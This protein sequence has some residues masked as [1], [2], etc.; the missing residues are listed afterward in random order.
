MCLYSHYFPV[1]N[2]SI[3][4][5]CSAVVVNEAQRKGVD[6]NKKLEFRSTC[7]FVLH[8]L[9]EDA[10]RNK[11]AAGVE[12]SG[13]AYIQ[14]SLIEMLQNSQ[15]VSTLQLVRERTRQKKK[16]EKSSCRCP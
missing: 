10:G 14:M 1:I 9:K 12:C 15:E 16:T 6:V 2:R 5:H 13:A 7:T 8:Y 4:V 11:G 3:S